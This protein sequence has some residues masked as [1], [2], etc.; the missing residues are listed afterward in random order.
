[1]ASLDGHLHDPRPY[2]DWQELEMPRDHA[3]EQAVLGAALLSRDVLKELLGM[4]DSA[5]FYDPRHETIWLAV[6]RL[7]EQ[8]RPV[9]AVTVSNQLGRDL[10]K[11]GG[12]AYLHT[13]M[14]AVPTAVNG[15]YY[16]EI[17]ETKTYARLLVSTGTRL[18]QMGRTEIEPELKAAARA[19]IQRVLDHER[20]G[21]EEP[22][23]LSTTRQVPPFPVGALPSWL[24]A[25]VEA[26]AHETQTPPD[27]AATVALGALATAAGGRV[28]V[29]VRPEV[30]WY[31][32]TNIY[33]VSALAPGSRKSPVYDSMT[34]PILEL[35][36]QIKPLIIE[37]YVDRKVADDY[38]AQMR[39]KAVKAKPEEREA[40]RD[41]ARAA[42]ADAEAIVVP[43]FPRLFLDDVTAETATSILDEQGG[44]IAVL[45]AESEIFNEM[46]GR[47][48]GKQNMNI[49]LKGHAGDA[50]RVDRTARAEAI[51]DPALTI[52]VCTQP[53]AL[54]ALAAV[55]GAAG[56]GLLARF[57][58]SIPEVNF[59][60]RETRPAPAA[61]SAHTN[62]SANLTALFRAL[63]ELDKPVVL[64]MN[65]DATAILIAVADDFEASMADGGRLAHLRDWGAKAV[66]AMMRIAG[67]LHL[68]EHQSC[69]HGT[70]IGPGTVMAARQIIE[71]YTAHSLAAFELMSTDETTV[72]A[73]ALLRWIESSGADQFDARQAY[74]GVSRSRF[75]SMGDL[76]APLAKL[77]Q[78]GY[79]RPRPQ[80][81]TAAR[82][83][84]PPSPKYLVHPDYVQR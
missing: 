24:R 33:C 39:E 75:P 36:A 71:Y 64:R 34:R 35:A 37:R 82:G 18:A 38:A 63:R 48:S 45:S 19:E 50:I 65:A 31:E 21:W 26:T 56:R 9:D 77:V 72:R 61:R 14:E 73:R 43:P 1:M 12:P 2:P 55:P 5:D 67:L 4:V 29:A 51:N 10:A 7:A 62:Y 20:R 3:A 60:T 28:R 66:G 17:L 30:G 76:E 42:A 44:R 49:F 11:V 32:P 54:A 13:C 68:A 15:P 57:L 78:H 70:P 22:V 16:A 53:A 46:A 23:A 58:Y 41:R 79:I 25:K 80:P 74:R 84:R 40:A 8:G 6:S 69:D 83:G 81:P 27:L 47:Y 52:N 59:G